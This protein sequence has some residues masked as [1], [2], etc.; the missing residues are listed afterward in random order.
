MN[1][2][3]L[4]ATLFATLM[5]LIPIS[6]VV[7]ISDISL[8]KKIEKIEDNNS[9]TETYDN[10]DCECEVV[11]RYDLLRVK[12]LMVRLKVVTNILLLRFGYIP[13]VAEKCYEILD[14]INSNR[15]LDYPIICAILLL[16]WYQLIYIDNFLTYIATLL[17]NNLIIKGIFIIFCF[18]FAYIGAYVWY[19]GDTY[20]CNLPPPELDIFH[21]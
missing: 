6:S 18:P 13:E 12:L 14:V 19:L 15:V 1:K 11:N 9:I 16:I 5:L 4:I 8:N 20:D 21:L 3:I 10:E 2:K 17:D 7:G